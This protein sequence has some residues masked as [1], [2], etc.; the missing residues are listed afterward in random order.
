MATIPGTPDADLIDGT[1]SDDTITGQGGND[2]IFA[3]SGADFIDLGSGDDWVDNGLGSDTVYGGQGDDTIFAGGGNDLLLGG[4]GNDR[5]FANDPGLAGLGSANAG[6]GDDD[7]R[8]YSTSGGTL[9]GGTGTDLISFTN[10]TGQ[11]LF[12]DFDN[13]LLDCGAAFSQGVTFLAFER[14]QVATGFGDDTILGGALDDRLKVGGGANSVDAKAGND[15]VAYTT[16]DASTLQGGD[17]DDT[18]TVDSG[19]NSLYFKVQLDGTID[20]GSL[21]DILGFEHFVAHGGNLADSVTLGTGNDAFCGAD[22]GDDATGGDG[23]D[24]LA[25][26][27]GNDTLAG[28]RGRDT[29]LGDNGNDIIRGGGGN[30]RI[31]GG[32][33]D[34]SLT[35][36]AGDDRIRCDTGDDTVAGGSGADIFLF[37]SLQSGFHTITDFDADSDALHFNRAYLQQGL[38]A[39]PLDPGLLSFG[40]AVGTQAQFV[41]SYSAVTDTTVLLWDPNGDDPSAGPFGL[42]FFTGE[43]AL[44]AADILIL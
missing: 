34:D 19:W 2:T 1:A 42:I 35:G 25:G 3:W 29:L 18:L 30:D 17:G 38:S 9:H 21:S 44:T 39:G 4:G 32:A 36:N 27:G 10:T 15:S 40:S 16:G 23:A 33:G 28:E 8:L 22:G 5:I 20:D 26:G 11:D 37:T 43:V 41:L 24:R 31:R 7:V 12:I 14:F 6:A 13:N